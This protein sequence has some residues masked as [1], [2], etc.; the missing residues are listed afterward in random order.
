MD[1]KEFQQ[2][3]VVG[4]T[5]VATVAYVFIAHIH[6]KNRRMLENVTLKTEL[7]NWIVKEGSDL[8][9]WEFKKQF[10]ERAKFIII[11]EQVGR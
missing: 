10:E 3:M 2:G 5:L 8:E 1:E 4:A 9:R 6:R 7:L 11:T